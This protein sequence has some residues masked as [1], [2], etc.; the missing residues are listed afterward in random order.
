M[1]TLKIGVRF[2]LGATLLSVS[3]ISSSA[4][5]ALIDSWTFRGGNCEP[6]GGGGV[7]CANANAWLDGNNLHIEKTYVRAEEP[8]GGH[9]PYDSEDAAAGPGSGG[10]D[11]DETHTELYSRL[12]PINMF[13][14][15]ANDGSLGQYNVTETVTNATGLTW[16]GFL[17]RLRRNEAGLAQFL[18]TPLLSDVFASGEVS[19]EHSEGPLVNLTWTDGNLPPAA[20]AMFSYGLSF[21]DCEVGLSCSD[22][23]AGGSDGFAGY[24]VNFQQFPLTRS[25]PE[26]STL[27][28]LGLGLGLAAR[29]RQVKNRP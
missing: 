4:S 5:A 6:P 15:L 28:L 13:L 19:G 7:I 29:R 23:L 10:H 2:V 9:E 27:A 26:P 25:V 16:D 14:T 17:H 24:V 22:Q 12:P 21:A 8:E 11:G 18:T 20:S 1:S 3:A